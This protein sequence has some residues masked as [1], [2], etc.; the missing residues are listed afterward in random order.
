MQDETTTTTIID[1]EEIKKLA[2]EIDGDKIVFEAAILNENMTLFA[3]FVN[4]LMGFMMGKGSKKK[5]NTVIR[6][7]EREIGAL[8]SALFNNRVLLRKI[9]MGT[10]SS[11]EIQRLLSKA[12][13][14][15]R[16]FERA[17]GISLP[18]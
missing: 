1:M 16:D 8:K 7:G 10:A 14:S 13:M 5:L 11:S 12:N 9:E 4:G 6:G 2:S 17:T 15:K 3:M 18:F